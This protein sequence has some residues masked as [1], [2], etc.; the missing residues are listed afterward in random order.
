MNWD[1][2]EQAEMD[3]KDF[4]SVP[5]TVV[6]KPISLEEVTGRL[7]E[8]QPRRSPGPDSVLNTACHLL[9]NP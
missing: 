6:P 7:A 9:P 4:L 3:M 8:L 2:D 5:V 1:F